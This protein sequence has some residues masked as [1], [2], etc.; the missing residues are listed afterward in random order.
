M[1][2]GSPR[3]QAVQDDPRGALGT[4]LQAQ[5]QGP[6][7]VAPGRAGEVVAAP[8]PVAVTQAGQAAPPTQA[9][10]DP[11]L[12][13]NAADWDAGYAAGQR[14]DAQAQWNYGSY[15][16]A[17]QNGYWLGR[18]GGGINPYT[19]AAQQQQQQQQGQPLP[20]DGRPAVGWSQP[21][22]AP[23][24]RPGTQPPAVYNPAPV[25][26]PP[27]PQQQQQQQQ[28]PFDLMTMLLL[29]SGLRRR[30]DE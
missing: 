18:S 26:V 1:S 29:L 22:P 17:W 12:A 10:L 3:I 25:Y 7:R 28:A 16:T 20:A 4:V 9:A 30:D 14:N 15:S 6:I 5:P 23:A 13:R 19:Q 21:Q 2:A 27:A 8:P 11:Q 24:Y